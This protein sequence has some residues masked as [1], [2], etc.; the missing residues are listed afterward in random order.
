MPDDEAI[1]EAAYLAAQAADP[2]SDL[3]GPADYKRAVTRTVTRR[4]L[5]R[6]VE[7]ARGAA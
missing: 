4:A 5:T 3:R 2:A 7:R 1:R 6:A